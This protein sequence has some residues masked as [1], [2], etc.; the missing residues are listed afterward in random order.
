MIYREFSA[1]GVCPAKT[2][3]RKPKWSRDG[4][5][6][7]GKNGQI[8][9][10]VKMGMQEVGIGQGI[11][12]GREGMNVSGWEVKRSKQDRDVPGK[13]FPPRSHGNELCNH[14]KWE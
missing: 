13:A 3:A 12:G 8:G 1:Q 10:G 5:I 4:E 7:A 11:L 2:H 14:R 6:A 9:V